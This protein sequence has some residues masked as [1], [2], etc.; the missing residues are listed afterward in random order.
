MLIEKTNSKKSV[1]KNVLGE[2]LQACG[3]DPVTGFFRTGDCQTGPNDE[4]IHTVCSRLTQ[5]FLEFSKSK[6]N[7]LM[8][9]LPQFG[10][11]GLKAGQKWCLCAE[12]WLEAANAGKAPP[13]DLDATH[14]KTLQIVPLETL[15]KH[16][17]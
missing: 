11:Q 6:G 4:G 15:K 13:V 1:K 5:E 17:L 9:P 2:A 16:K 8:T 12:R 10:F 7:D 14:E 3:K